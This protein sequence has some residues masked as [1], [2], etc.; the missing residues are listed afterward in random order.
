MQYESERIEYKSQMIEDLYREVIAFANTEGGVIYIGINDQGNVTG[1]DNVDETYNRITNGIRDVI[2]PDVTM[3]VRYVLQDDKVIRI[4]VG[5]G[6]NKPYFLKN[7]GMKPSGVYVRQGASSVQASFEQIRK[8]IKDADGDHFE[9]LRCLKQDLTFQTA[10]DAFLRY[11][12][13]FSE[14]K[15]RALGITNHDIFSNLALLVSD[16]C[17]HTTKIAVFND[18]SCTEFRDSR[19]FGG[20]LFKQFEDSINYLDLCNKTVSTIKGMIRTDKKIIRM[21]RFERHC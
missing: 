9:N 15:Y 4:E 2:V 6:L 1:I 11:G 10:Q 3:F 12:V 20:S 21:K 17:L 8:M 14:E 13:E 19:E 5:Q 18:E 16:Q 7:K